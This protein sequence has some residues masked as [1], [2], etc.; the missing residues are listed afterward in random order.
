MGKVDAAVVVVVVAAFV[1]IKSLID[2]INIYIYIQIHA[3]TVQPN[4]NC[5]NLRSVYITY[6]VAV[7][8]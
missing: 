8:V 5:I 2:L 3:W 6:Y 1:L 4:Q 7:H